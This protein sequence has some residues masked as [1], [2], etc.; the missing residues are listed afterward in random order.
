MLANLRALFGVL[1]DIMLLRRGPEQLPASPALLAALVLL[2]LVVYSIA[3]TVMAPPGAQVPNPWLVH[4]VSLALLLG[5]FRVT[6][7]L[8]HKPERYV[9]TMIAVFGVNLLAV[10]T[11][12]LFAALAPYAAQEAGAEP[13]PALLSLMVLA[14]AFWFAAVMVRIVKTSF[15]WPWFAAIAFM[16]STGFGIYVVLGLIF[17]STSTA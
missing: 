6:L 3:S 13:A 10:P 1:V 12:P 14:V 7:L 4:F 16:L 8:L 11:L 9:Q 2:N 15:E 5:W 17:G